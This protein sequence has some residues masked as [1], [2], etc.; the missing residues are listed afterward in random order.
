MCDAKRSFFGGEI[1]YGFLSINK[2]CTSYCVLNFDTNLITLPRL[3]PKKANKAVNVPLLK[4]NAH[5]DVEV[6]NG[7]KKNSPPQYLK[8]NRNPLPCT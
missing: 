4:I 1:H 7:Q 2:D 8:R 6:E 5:C 3:W